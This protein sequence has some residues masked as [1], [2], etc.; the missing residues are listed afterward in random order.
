VGIAGRAHG[1]ARGSPTPGGS[2]ARRTRPWSRGA[3][4]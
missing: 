3:T 2:S 1:R 4:P